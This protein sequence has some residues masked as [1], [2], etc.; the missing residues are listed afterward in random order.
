MPN[1]IKEAE[2]IYYLVLAQKKVL[3]KI[4][5]MADKENYLYQFV[6][7]EYYEKVMQVGASNAK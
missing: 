6:D 5:T 2:K 7:L 3:F 1:K 4:K